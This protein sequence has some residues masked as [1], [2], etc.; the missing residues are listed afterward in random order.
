MTKF[1]TFKPEWK[2]QNR[3]PSSCNVCISPEV[4]INDWLKNTPGIEIISWQ[5]TAVGKDNEL[6]ITVQYEEN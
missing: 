1:I 5:T 6:Y 4:Q 2:W 3:G